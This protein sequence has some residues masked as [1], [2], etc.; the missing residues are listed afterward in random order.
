ML[1]YIID[2]DLCRQCGKQIRTGKPEHTFAAE[3]YDTVPSDTDN[4]RYPVMMTFR[5]A[6]TCNLACI[7]CKG[8]LSS[9]ICTER[10]KRP[11]PQSPYGKH[12]FE[13]L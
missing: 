11:I 13:N 3:Q 10:E 6:N 8:D 12:F 4:P 9:R 2:E 1:D 5:L 7:M